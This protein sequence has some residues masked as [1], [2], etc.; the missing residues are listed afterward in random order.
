MEFEF[1][2]DTLMLQD[3]LRR[4]IDKEVRPLEMKYFAT[5]VLEP[6]EQ[7]HLRAVIE[8]M[9]LWG[10]TVPEKFGGGGLDTMTACLL[11]EELGKTFV[12]VDIGEVPP[13]LYACRGDQVK[14]YLMPA[15]AGN[16]R[17]ILAAREPSVMHPEQWRTMAAS[18]G[19]GYIIQGLKLLNSVPA[20]TDF[21]VV[22]ASTHDGPTA[23][24]VDINHPGLVVR[25]HSEIT[26]SME[27]CQVGIDALLGEWGKALSLGA[28]EAPRKWVHIGARYVGLAGRLLEMA[29]IYAADWVSLGEPLKTR[30]AIRRMLAEIRIQIEGVRWIV[31]HAAW[32]ADR[33]ELLRIPAAEVHLASGEMLKKVVDLVTIIFGGPGSSREIEILQVVHDTLSWEAL[34]IGLESARLIIAD[35]LL[36]HLGKRS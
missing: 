30:P 14:R 26:L 29:T 16:R 9:G 17:V 22:F 3:M 1:P 6:K 32:Q 24:L 11:E 25:D 8:Q 19:E 20:S 21:L 12:P 7:N 23:F 28:E 35:D 15:L 33:G 2:P 10:I 27:Q 5:G 31:Y 34:E 4:F 36:A 13:F 18:A